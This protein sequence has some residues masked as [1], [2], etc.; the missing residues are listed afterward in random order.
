MWTPET[1]NLE[2]L[3]H[4][5]AVTILKGMAASIAFLFNALDTNGDG[6]L[7]SAEIDAAPDILR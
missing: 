5:D 2:T 6:R 4:D 1:I 3:T 7:S